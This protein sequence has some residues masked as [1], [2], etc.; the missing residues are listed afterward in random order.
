MVLG[1]S[2]GELFVVIGVGMTLFGTQDLPKAGRMAGRLAGWAAGYMLKA[3]GHFQRL[4]GDTQL[5]EMH[6]ELQ[7]R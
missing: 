5:V 6:K 7:V 2:Y 4:A 1:M 3:R